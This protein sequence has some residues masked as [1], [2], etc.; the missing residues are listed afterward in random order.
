MNRSLDALRKAF[1]KDDGPW[2]IKDEK[3]KGPDFGK[4]LSALQSSAKTSAP[5]AS[6]RF[7]GVITVIL[8]MT[9]ILLGST[10]GYL[11]SPGQ[12]SA[13]KEAPRAPSLVPT[14]SFLIDIPSADD[15]GS[16]LAVER[17]HLR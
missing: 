5:A 4:R 14:R 13:P 17:A 7:R 15:E 1:Q 9:L 12:E 6:T 2:K 3:V 8:I 16:R 11:S 10:I